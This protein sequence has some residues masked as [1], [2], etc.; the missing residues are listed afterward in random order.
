[1]VKPEEK[2]SKKS[3]AL[4]AGAFHQSLVERAAAGYLLVGGNILKR[5]I[6]TG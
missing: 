2:T 6:A 3:R 4:G 1:M 5:A